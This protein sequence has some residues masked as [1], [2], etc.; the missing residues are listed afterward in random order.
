M[1][2]KRKIVLLLLLAVCV[3]IV[4]ARDY[5]KFN[6]G[7]EAGIETAAN[8]GDACFGWGLT[9]KLNFSKRIGWEM[10]TFRIVAPF[11]NWGK[12]EY[13]NIRMLTGVQYKS[14]NFVGDWLGGYINVRGGYD[15]WD[16][17]GAITGEA[18]VG[19]VLWDDFQLGYSCEW[20][21]Y[22]GAD[23]IHAFILRCYF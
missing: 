20:L 5:K 14:P 23:L 4:N 19:L 7:V 1:I 16:G 11:D 18:G 22:D 8:G 9:S 6:W 21:D 17:D 2:M 10:L 12:T 15:L 13:S 3:N